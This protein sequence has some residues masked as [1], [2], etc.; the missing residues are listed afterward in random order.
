VAQK[1]EKQNQSRKNRHH[2]KEAAMGGMGGNVHGMQQ[3]KNLPPARNGVHR[4][5]P[6]SLL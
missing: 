5:P 1:R 4:H 3:I 2:Q 6:F